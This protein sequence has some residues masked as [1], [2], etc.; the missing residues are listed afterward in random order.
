M[1]LAIDQSINQSFIASCLRCNVATET[2]CIKKE[3]KKW[4]TIAS[5]R[6][7]KIYEKNELQ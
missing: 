3:R 2:T 7:K 5:L 1:H 6:E 4:R